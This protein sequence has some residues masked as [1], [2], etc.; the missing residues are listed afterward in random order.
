M[1]EKIHNVE[2]QL[3]NLNRSL[4]ITRMI[5]SGDEKAGHAACMGENCIKEFW[6]EIM[7]ERSHGGP[8]CRIG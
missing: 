4:Y 2:L 1:L 5:K 7:K 8:M 3:H 6:L